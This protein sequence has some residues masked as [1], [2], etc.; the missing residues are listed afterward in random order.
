MSKRCRR[1]AT[2]SLSRLPTRSI[3]FWRPSVTTISQMVC[4]TPYDSSFKV[5]GGQTNI[6]VQDPR[7][8]RLLEL[9]LGKRSHPRPSSR[10]L[11]SSHTQNLPRCCFDATQRGS[12]SCSHCQRSGRYIPSTIIQPPRP[13]NSLD[14]TITSHTHDGRFQ[15][16]SYQMPEGPP[17]EQPP[18]LLPSKF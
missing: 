11:S 7:V 17:R 10:I 5:W 14:E 1:K 2:T 8:S 3:S 13:R 9:R 4:F 18:L 15:N 16:I 12:E 6:T